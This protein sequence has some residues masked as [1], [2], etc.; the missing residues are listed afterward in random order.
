MATR[1]RL[2]RRGRKGYKLFDIVVADSRSP[3]D[4]R[5][6]EKLGTYNPNVHPFSVELNEESA[7]NWIMKGAQPSETARKLLSDYGVM[8]RKHLQV[9]VDKG[10]IK[11]E[12]ADKKYQAWKEDKAKRVAA[13]LEK[14]SKDEQQ[15]L[16]D[17]RAA[18][19]KVAQAR[20]EAI[21]KKELAVE[22]EAVAEETAEASADAVEAP[23]AEEAAKAEEQPAE[24]APA[25]VAQKEEAPKEEAAP[26]KEEV[27]PEAAK[28]EAP[29]EK[30]E[31]KKEE[32]KAEAPEEKKEEKKEEAPKAAAEE[33]PEAKEEN[34]EA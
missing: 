15:Q 30:K 16:K 5:F 7:F 13:L 31:E 18:E 22:E 8:L 3:R 1:I 11:Q 20:Q 23:A 28:A 33:K 6:I 9:G 21:Q 17:R 34:K 4:G 26:E 32:A 2:A 12:E 19:Q 10:A 24:E 25:E 27:A 29:E 14:I